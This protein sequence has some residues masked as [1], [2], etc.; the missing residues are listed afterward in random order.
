[1]ITDR[2]PPCSTNR[3]AA[4]TLGPIEPL[5]KWPS[6]AYARIVDDG[7]GADVLGLGRAVAQHR[8]RDVGGDDEYVGLHRAREQRGAEVLVDDRLDA[9]Q[10]AVGLAHDRDAA[11]AVGD[12]HEPGLDQRLHRRARPGSRAAP[13]EATTRRQPFSPRSSQVSPCS[14]SNAASSAGRNRPIGLVGRVNPGSSASTS[15]RVT[16]VAVR[17]VAPRASRAASRA[18]IST[19]PRVACVWAP[20]Q[21]SGTGGTTAAASSF[22]TSRLPTCGPLPWVITTSTSWASRSATAAIATWAAAIWSSGRARPSA[23]VIAL[24][25][26]ASRTLMGRT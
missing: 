18:F 19:K 4:S 15:V 5:A 8:V 12:H 24:P 9:A 3:Q 1:M 10:R 7:D 22:L 11:A 14:T 6:A 16:T 13:G 2:L 26:S 21:S 23:F 25:P 20:H 17:P